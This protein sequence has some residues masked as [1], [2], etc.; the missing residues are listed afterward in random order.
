MPGFWNALLLSAACSAMLG[1][2]A[3]L[4]LRSLDISQ[5]ISQTDSATEQPAEEAALKQYQQAAELAEKAVAAF[6]SANS[7]D[8]DTARLDLTLRERDL[9]RSAL[10]KIEAIPARSSLH[11]RAI[12]K[13]V[14]YEKLLA[15]A[16]N[17][18]AKANQNFIVGIIQAA[19]TNPSSVHVTLCQIEVSPTDKVVQPAAQQKAAKKP[20][21]KAEI[22]AAT[23]LPPVLLKKGKLES[24][25]CRQHQG[26][27]LMASAASL[28]KVP[29]ALALVHRTAEISDAAGAKPT[30]VNLSQKIAID[31][32]NFTENAAGATIEIGEEYTLQKVM[33]HMIS[34]SDNIATNQLIDYLGYDNINQTLRQLGYLQTTVG[35]KLAGD[36]VMPVGFGVGSNQTSTNEITAMVAQ[37][38]KSNALGDKDIVTALGNQSDRELGYEALMVD[39]QAANL[40]TSSTAANKAKI[41]WLG[42][43]T[44]QNAQVLASTSIMQIGQAHYVLT[45]ALDNNGDAYALRQVISGIADHLAKV[46]PLVQR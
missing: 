24:R 35:H 38:Y 31:P 21:P 20:A 6:N 15:N 16:E 25:Y 42:E 36:Q 8:S 1:L 10:K 7:A 2:A 32:G 26:D 5:N 9:W 34:D 37:M 40:S 39:D 41:E 45:V 12:A 22:T 13:Q 19:N 30:R 14:Q 3:G 4:Q 23:P 11:E 43:K 27:Q 28:I 29:I 33:S 17:K 18:L 46:G 44:A